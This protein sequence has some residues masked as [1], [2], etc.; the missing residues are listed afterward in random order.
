MD[1]IVQAKVVR[2][3]DAID[4]M[5][6]IKKSFPSKSKANEQHEKA[7]DEGVCESRKQFQSLVDC[8]LYDGEYERYRLKKRMLKQKEEFPDL[9]LLDIVDTNKV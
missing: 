4:N 5:I 8:L 2:L 3:M 9:S 6:E 7:L 1:E